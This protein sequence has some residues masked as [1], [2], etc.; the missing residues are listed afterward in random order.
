MR[1]LSRN[2][3]N[4]VYYK[5]FNAKDINEYP[6]SGMD[7]LFINKNLKQKRKQLFWQT[8]QKAKELSYKFIWTFNGQIF[9]RK[10]VGSN[11]IQVKSV[12]NLNNL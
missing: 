10:N 2:K 6:V 9:V 4:E 12:N 5:W 8:K 3:R 7:R 1:F 11:K